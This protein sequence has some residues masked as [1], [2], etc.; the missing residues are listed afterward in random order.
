VPVLEQ[1]GGVVGF[2]TVDNVI[3]GG[4]RRAVGGLI[5]TLIDARGLVI[6][7]TIAKAILQR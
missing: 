7:F 4:S 2:V 1:D 6:S 3:R 5:R